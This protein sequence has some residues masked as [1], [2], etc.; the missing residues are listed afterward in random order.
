MANNTL[1][2]H[3][4]CWVT[5]EHQNGCPLLVLSEIRRVIS[6]LLVLSRAAAAEGRESVALGSASKAPLHLSCDEVMVMSQTE[7]NI[8]N[9]DVIALSLFS[10]C[11]YEL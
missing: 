4:D 7:N 3:G 8:L 2:T 1:I 11:F 9:T 10:I 6:V 5:A